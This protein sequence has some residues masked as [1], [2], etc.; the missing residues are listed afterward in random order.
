MESRFVGVYEK[1]GSG[2]LSKE[3]IA[4]LNGALGSINPIKEGW[5]TINGHPVLIGEEEPEAKDPLKVERAKKSHK[6]VTKE[7]KAIAT[8][9]EIKVCNVTGGEH[10][11]DN[12]PFDVL[13]PS[14]EHP[15]IGIEVKTILEGETGKITMHK[16]SLARKET[17]ANDKGI[18]T[19]TVAINERTGQAY[20]W[21]GL[22]SFRTD[23]K[24][25]MPIDLNSIPRS[26]K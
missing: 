9:N 19:Y 11:P 8:K 20:L 3:D 6:G 24:G 4:R 26:L 25:T 16:K 17:F 18:K 21:D 15:E 5:V 22:G 23:A 1:T 14:I 13:I 2:K 12:H 7:K 10:T